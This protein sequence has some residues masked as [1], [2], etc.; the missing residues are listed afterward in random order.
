MQ[1]PKEFPI[2][3]KEIKYDDLLE[4]VSDICQ[5]ILDDIVHVNGKFHDRKSAIG[6][7]KDCRHLRQWQ[8]L[9]LGY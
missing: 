5:F 9:K 4:I 8:G 6:C 1:W 2:E 3:S 7:L